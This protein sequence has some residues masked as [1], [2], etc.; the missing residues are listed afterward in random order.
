MVFQRLNFAQSIRCLKRSTEGWCIHGWRPPQPSGRIRGKRSG[1]RFQNQRLV[2]LRALIE[3]IGY[4]HVARGVAERHYSLV[5]EYLL[6]AMSTIMKEEATAELMG[7]WNEAYSENANVFEN[8]ETK[9]HANLSQVASVSGFPDTRVVS[10]EEDEGY[11]DIYIHVSMGM[12][13]GR[14]PRACSSRWMLILGLSVAPWRPC[15]L[16]END[17]TDSLSVCR[18]RRRGLRWPSRTLP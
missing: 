5:G 4:K 6:H 9:L 17:L 11:R 14:F 13:I 3:L 10:V 1:I 2:L 12:T 15:P 16:F 8:T 18:S 7:A